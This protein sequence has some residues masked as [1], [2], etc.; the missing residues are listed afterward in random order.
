M[1]TPIQNTPTG[2]QNK[3]SLLPIQRVCHDTNN[4]RFDLFIDGRHTIKNT[5]LDE[6]HQPATEAL[7]T[8]VINKSLERLSKNPETTALIKKAQEMRLTLQVVH[9]EWSFY[10]AS[11]YL[12]N[13]NIERAKNHQQLLEIGDVSPEIPEHIGLTQN[14]GET[15]LRYDETEQSVK[16]DELYLRTHWQLLNHKQ[17]NVDAINKEI[18]ARIAHALYHAVTP[19]DGISKAEETEALTLQYF[20]QQYKGDVL[21]FKTKADAQKAAEREIAKN[22]LTKNLK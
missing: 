14:L 16:I 15:P 12:D 3:E 9:E 10:E 18:D 7:Q 13:I 21:S 17:R 6:V 22:P 4:T 5:H 11:N 2:T 19:D 1:G 8:G 20:I